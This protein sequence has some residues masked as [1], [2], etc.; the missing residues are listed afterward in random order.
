MSTH[1]YV[2]LKEAAKKHNVDEQVLTQLISAGMI[3]AKKEAGEIL[4]AVDRNG[5]G[6]KG[7]HT[8]EEIIA[9]KFGDLRGQPITD[10]APV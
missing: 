5:N 6:D 10:L 1:I 9:A 7:L 8:K 2:P 4:V 3:R